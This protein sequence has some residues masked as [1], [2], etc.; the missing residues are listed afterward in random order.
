MKE[1][2]FKIKTT[3]EEAKQRFLNFMN[4]DKDYTW[5][6]IQKC[7]QI[8]E[9]YVT[10]REGFVLFED[11][12]GEAFWGLETQSWL[13][14]AKTDELIYASYDESLLNAEFIKIENSVCIQEFRICE[15]EIESD[16]RQESTAQ[17]FTNWIDVAS[18]LEE[19]LH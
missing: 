2:N 19:N 10:E 9:V 1:C 7:F 6:S 11:M 5:N 4:Y 15:D 12:N 17:P 16:I 8:R 3:L 18:F 14:F 13:N